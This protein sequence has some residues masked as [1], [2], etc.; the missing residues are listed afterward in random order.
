[1]SGAF[2]L[3]ASLLTVAE[4]SAVVPSTPYYNRADH[5]MVEAESTKQV[6]QERANEYLANVPGKAGLAGYYSY[7]DNAEHEYYYNYGS[8]FYYLGL[9]LA[10]DDLANF[11]AYISDYSAIAEAYW[12]V[13]S[14][15]DDTY[16]SYDDIY[17]WGGGTSDYL[18]FYDHEAGSRFND[19]IAVAVDV[20]VYF[21]ENVPSSPNYPIAVFYDA[22]GDGVMGYYTA[23]GSYY[24]HVY[25]SY[26][27]YQEASDEQSRWYE[28]AQDTARSFYAYGSYY[29]TLS[30][31]ND[32]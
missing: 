26:M 20:G 21:A 6:Y 32:E 25:A 2:V 11:D 8:S 28:I 4:V 1:M 7:L 27:L 31:Q 14:L 24:Y 17:D 23:Y 5:H 29:D 3:A 15:V 13:S 9:G 30:T 16:N 19:A 22:V 12:D 10:I 18:A